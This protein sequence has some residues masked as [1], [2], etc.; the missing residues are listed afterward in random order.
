MLQKLGNELWY[1]NT[2]ADVY[3]FSRIPN[4]NRMIMDKK[5]LFN[6]TYEPELRE[7]IRREI[8]RKFS[9][10]LWPKS[11][12]G[13]KVSAGIPDN[14]DLKLVIL[15]PDDDGAQIPEWIERRGESFR[16]YKN[17]LFFALADTA[18]FAR[19][20][21][22]VKTYLALQEIK[23][24]VDS[25]ETPQL[26]TRRDE[27]QRRL[28]AIRRDFSFNVRRMYHALQIGDRRVDLGQPVAGSETLS[29]WYWR[30]LTSVDVGAI[31]TQLGYRILATKFLSNQERVAASAVLEQFYKN[32]DLPAPADPAVVARAIQLGVQERAFGLAELRDDGIDPATL[33]Y[34]EEIP[35]DAIT[36]EAGIYLVSKERCEAIRAQMAATEEPET[37]TK[38]SPTPGEAEVPTPTVDTGAGVPGTGVAIPPVERFKRV[39]LVVSGIPASK[40]A[41]VNR[42]ILMPISRA[43]GDFEFTL[44]IDV[45]GAAGLAQATLESQVKE[46]IRQIGATLRDEVLE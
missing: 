14:R 10:Y 19:L 42:G 16:E 34:G 35:L 7:I 6:E 36:F 4:L 38:V 40:I 37:G 30:E 24:G 27:I 12:S 9:T 44:E 46:T 33:R 17:T 3:Y 8:G 26:E 20:R 23:A 39:R 15:R 43:V 29:S 28:G 25:G 1:L 45:S 41:D 5:E 2:R 31:A 18:A 11:G 32:P 21:E 22:D 13:Y